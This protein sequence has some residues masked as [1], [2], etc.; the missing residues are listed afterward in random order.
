MQEEQIQY[1][2][3]QSKQWCTESRCDGTHNDKVE[4]VCTEENQESAEQLY[5]EVECTGNRNTVIGVYLFFRKQISEHGKSDDNTA[6]DNAD[7]EKA[8]IGK[9]VKEITGTAD[10]V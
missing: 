4:Q 1:G 9:V 6:A 8:A 7:E 3:H 2:R 10:F 5:E